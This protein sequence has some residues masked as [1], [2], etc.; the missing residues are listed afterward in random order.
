MIE[1]RRLILREYA[2]DD[3]DALYAML[4]DPET[5]RHYPAPFDEKRVRGWIAWNRGNYARYGFG[6]WAVVLKADGA[7]IGDCGV[8]MQNIDGETLPEIG[9]HIDKRYWHGGYAKEAGRAVRDWA[10]TNTGFEAL[11]AYMKCTNAASAA[12]A[13]A[14]G[15][16]KV[17][18]YTDRANTRTLAF[19]ITRQEWMELPQKVIHH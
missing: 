12:T 13:R 4:S 18:E 16:R 15:M 5:M 3:F 1:T 11:W 7:F 10:F 19:A 8:T 6:L 14:I 17:K 2:M 9:Y